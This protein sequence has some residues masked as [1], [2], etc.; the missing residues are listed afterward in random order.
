M[1]MM[2]LVSIYMM[3]NIRTEKSC[4]IDSSLLDIVLPLLPL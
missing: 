2:V 4:D 3:Y 1:V